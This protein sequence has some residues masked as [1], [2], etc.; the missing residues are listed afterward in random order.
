MREKD[1]PEL[2]CS[3]YEPAEETSNN[4]ILV[5][6]QEQATH[7]Y[8]HGHDESAPNWMKPYPDIT[9]S[10]CG[11][12]KPTPPDPVL[13][14]APTAPPPPIRLTTPVRF[15][16]LRARKHKKEFNKTTESPKTTESL[17]TKTFDFGS[18]IVTETVTEWYTTYYT[19][20]YPSPK[21]PYE[22][23]LMEVQSPDLPP[24]RMSL[25]V[26]LL[27]VFTVIFIGGCFVF[28]LWLGSKATTDENRPL[29]QHAQSPS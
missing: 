23:P 26:V 10:N 18:T 17:T 29:T 3:R 27:G 1:P 11:V 28:S 4:N 15:Q 8:K 20:S 22:P 2:D 13:L 7:F 6:K 24:E 5:P 16:E 19:T 14:F 25:L 12:D 9:L 21:I